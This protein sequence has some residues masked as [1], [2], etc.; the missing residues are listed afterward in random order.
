MFTGLVE[1]VGTVVSVERQDGG[2]RVTVEAPRVSVDAA[3]GDSIS[4]NGACLTVVRRAAIRLCF[5]AVPETV[6]RTN[7]KSARVGETVNLERSLVVGGRVGGHFVS[8][9]VDGMATLLEVSR[10]GS[11]Q[12][13]RFG[14][15]AALSRYVASKGSV[16]LDGISLTVA[17]VSADAFTVW[18]IPHTLAHTTIGRRRRGDALNLETD[19]L[20]R[21]AERLLGLHGDGLTAERLAAAGFG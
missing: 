16:A 10:R 6:E 18:I 14:M 8:G 12:V 3:V 7:L 9:H 20:A 11:A 19:I 2:A 4:V 21:Y 13:L 1:E 15:P 17:E 5:D